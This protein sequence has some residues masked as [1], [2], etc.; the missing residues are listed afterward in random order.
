VVALDRGDGLAK[1]CVV[2]L[3]TLATIPKATLTRH[4][5]ALSVGKVRAPG[6]A[7]RFALGLSP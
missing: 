2:N 4:L 1:P 6:R 7:L 3:D 5:G